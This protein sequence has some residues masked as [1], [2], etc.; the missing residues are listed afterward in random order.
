MT[1]LSQFFKIFS[2]IDNVLEAN[3]EHYT[4]KEIKMQTTN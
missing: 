4:V 3:L 2:V 1:K